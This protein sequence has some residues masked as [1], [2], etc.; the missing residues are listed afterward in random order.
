[1][2]LG[3][4]ARRS[5]PEQADPVTD[6]RR[7]RW[8]GWRAED[9]FVQLVADLQVVG[10]G[11]TLRNALRRALRDPGLD[12]AYAR[13]GSGGWVD[14]LGHVMTEPVPTEGRAV[15]V[16]DRGGKPFA[17]LI[18]DP[19]LLGTPDRLRAAVDAAS[20]AFENEQRKADLRAE[21]DELRASRARIVQEADLER[22]RV[23]RNLHDGAQ[24]RLVGL[25][26]LLRSAQRHA[27]AEDSLRALI[28]E[29]TRGLEE[30]HAELRELARGIHPAVVTASGLAGALETLA[31]RP[32]VPVE[33]HVDVPVE[34]AAQIEV[35]A[36]YVV[37]E[38]I[39]NTA[40]HAGATHVEVS[41]T[42][43]DGILRVQ[44]SDDGR[45]AAIASPG[46]G[47][48]GLA[49]RV[50]AVSGRLE[51][52]SAQGRG[53]TVVAELPL[54]SLE[55]PERSVDSLAALRWMGWETFEIPA[56]AY[57]Q[58]T[59]EDQRAWVRGMFAC[60]GGVGLVTTAQREWA[61]AY[62]TAAGAAAWVL[63]SLRSHELDETVA[64]VLA[65]P[66]ML[67]SARG[68]LYDAIRM[69]SSDGEL[70][71]DE[72]ARLRH[73][74]AE[75]GLADDVLDDLL[76]LVAEEQDLRRRRY[77]AITAPVLLR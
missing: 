25:S 4:L 40:K 74:C 52:T 66:G 15:T 9:G 58:L 63:D 29:A 17:A 27:A 45:G 22:R 26:L 61:V 72:L 73:S 2:P 3:G 60:A 46:S 5:S 33:L 71:P 19:R 69:C 56:E 36:Y 77:D 7:L 6:K 62:E 42:A 67:H 38:A 18:H 23:E 64:D 53:T 24:Q 35:V 59:Q 28:D 65:L 76:G 20:L 30:A 16:V 1:M 10:P 44:V 55:V 47:L 57:S 11:N 49:D 34:V 13:F 14:E 51:V 68:L 75:L 43:A 21:V 31:E 54:V 70:T 39:T 48:E 12:I 41:A 50:A 8:T 37:A 32:G